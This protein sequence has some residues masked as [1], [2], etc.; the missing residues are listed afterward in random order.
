MY[1]IRPDISLITLLTSIYVAVDELY[2]SFVGMFLGLKRIQYH[3]VVTLISKLLLLGFIVA[4]TYYQW[5]LTA[6]LIGYGLI[7][8]LR[9][10]LAYAI[11]VRY[12]GRFHLVW[13]A[14]LY[15]TIPVQAF[16]FFMLTLFDLVHFK[17]DTVMLGF[18]QNYTVVSTYESS[19]KFL[20]A[21]RFVIYPIGTIFFPFWSSMAASGHFD[22]I[23]RSGG[24]IVAG[25]GLARGRNSSD[26]FI[27]GGYHY[28][29]GIRLKIF[30]GNIIAAHFIRQLAHGLYRFRGLRAGQVNSRRN[31]NAQ[32]HRFLSGAEHPVESL[33]HS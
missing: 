1:L 19:Y 27:D 25:I 13:N 8:S 29:V 5:S 24:L 23:K 17:I 32:N 2:Y 9:V 14:T 6:I 10:G 26:H 16:G 12:I 33:L 21:S 28:T 15:Y 22:R 20:E 4:A 11:T 3:L 31:Q 30:S 18:M 7:N